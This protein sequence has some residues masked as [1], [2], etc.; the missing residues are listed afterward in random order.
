MARCGKCGLFYFYEHETVEQKFAG[1][2]AWFN[3]EMSRDEAFEE[4]KCD[5]FSHPIPEATPME[6]L[7]YK[8]TKDELRN[9]YKEARIA[10][11]SALVGIITGLAGLGLGILNLFH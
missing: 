1:R 5:D 4:R 11:M 9:T 10:T 6:Q 2:C 3:V 7:E 8:M